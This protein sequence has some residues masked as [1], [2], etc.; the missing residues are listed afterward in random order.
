MGGD[1]PVGIAARHWLDVSRMHFVHPPHGS[2]RLPSLL[3]NEH[4]VLFPGLGRH[5]RSIN[6]PPTSS[7]DVKERVELYL[8]APSGPSRPV[9]GQIY[10]GRDSSVGIASRYILDCPGIESRLGRD[11]PHPSRQTLG[12]T[13]PSIHWVPDLFPG[14]KAWR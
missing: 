1:V 3:Y 4:R 8:Y 10:M 5:R 12:P 14:G 6:H 11:F 2:W 9:I 13:Q 7:T